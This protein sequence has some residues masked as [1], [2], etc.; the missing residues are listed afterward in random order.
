[1]A[2]IAE[3]RKSNGILLHRH[4]KTNCTTISLEKM[5]VTHTTINMNTNKHMHTV[6]LHTNNLYVCMYV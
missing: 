6:Y 4:K 2:P 5:H 1:L 3:K